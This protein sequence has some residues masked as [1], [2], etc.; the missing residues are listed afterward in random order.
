[1]GG[2]NSVVVTVIGGVGVAEP[3]GPKQCNKLIITFST[4]YMIS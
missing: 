4:F 2:I 1:M 3:V